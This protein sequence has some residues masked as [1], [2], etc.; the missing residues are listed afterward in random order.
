M[1][2]LYYYKYFAATQLLKLTAK[3]PSSIL[4]SLTSTFHFSLLISLES[5]RRYPQKKIQSARKSSEKDFKQ[6]SADNFVMIDGKFLGLNSHFFTSLLLLSILHSHYFPDLL[7]SSGYPICAESVP[8]GK[9][10]AV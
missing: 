5:S 6:I 1:Y 7:S 9:R 2:F 8:S 10:Q 4:Q 3:S